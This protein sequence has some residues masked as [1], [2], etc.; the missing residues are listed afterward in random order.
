MGDCQREISFAQQKENHTVPIKMAQSARLIFT[1][2][3]TSE[4]IPLVSCLVGLGNKGADGSRCPVCVDAAAPSSKNKRRNTGGL[5]IT[6]P[7]SPN[8]GHVLA[9]DCG[10]LWWEAMLEI[11][12]SEGLARLDA[13]ILTHEHADAISGLDALR[14]FTLNFGRTSPLPVF[15]S[16]STYEYLASTVPYLL[17]PPVSAYDRDVVVGG[18][19]DCA[20]RTD[21]GIAALQYF[22]F[23]PY[24]P[25]TAYGVS[26]LPFPVRHGAIEC[27][28]R[29]VLVAVVFEQYLA[30]SISSAGV[31]HRKFG[32][33][34]R[35]ENHS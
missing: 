7:A 26:V 30:I 4:G 11:Y 14:D 29:G 6:N 31:S 8:D 21:G 12:P 25:F 17:T 2:T 33:H 3:G 18:L 20:S 35:C 23:E 22:V 32:V 19:P 16:K 13:V 28:V 15:C 24:V 34:E 27:M 10:K 9:I 1:G 5:V